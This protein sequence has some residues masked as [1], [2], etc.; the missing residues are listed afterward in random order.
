MASRNHKNHGGVKWLIAQQ[1]I[2]DS[3]V[4]LFFLFIIII[5]IFPIQHFLF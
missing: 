5:P 4:V 2:G 1:A 3:S